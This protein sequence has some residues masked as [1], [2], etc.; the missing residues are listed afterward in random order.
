M[1]SHLKDLVFICSARLKSQCACCKHFSC[2]VCLLLPSQ[3][4][5]IHVSVCWTGRLSGVDKDG[6]LTFFYLSMF[7]WS[8][9]RMRLLSRVKPKA[10]MESVSFSLQTSKKI[11]WRCPSITLK[12]NKKIVKIAATKMSVEPRLSSVLS[13]LILAV[14]WILINPSLLNVDD[15]FLKYFL[16]R[17]KTRQKWVSELVKYLFLLKVF[18]RIFFT[19]GKKQ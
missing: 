12:K 19:G 13:L 14:R 2:H 10:W 15:L 16:R 18:Q 17:F 5:V 8:M 9:R 1:L 3:N 4:I 6:R 7:V 11:L